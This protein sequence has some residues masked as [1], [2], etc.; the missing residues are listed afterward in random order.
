LPLLF[1][2][3]DKV[4]QANHTNSRNC[5]QEIIYKKFMSS[6]HFVREGQEPALLIAGIRSFQGI[7]PLLEWAPLVMVMEPALE[8][9]LTLGIKIDVVLA[10]VE[11]FNAVEL[12]MRDQMPVDIISYKPDQDP[13][14]E[15][16]QFLMD[17][18]RAVYVVVDRINDNVFEELEK[19]C[20]LI[21]IVITDGVMRWI[22]V[23]SKFEKWMPALSHVRVHNLHENKIDHTG[24][25][26]TSQDE[27]QSIKDGK[28]TL[29]SEKFFW[30]GEKIE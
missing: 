1:V 15:G 24:L 10:V 26:E 25:I 9:V 13:L 16:I 7:E 29:R 14:H 18:H 5:R 2:L 19:Y 12:Q 17:S 6:H 20:K 22:P 8:K 21:N 4:Q 11:N 3:K 23:V 27:Y 28:I 30:V